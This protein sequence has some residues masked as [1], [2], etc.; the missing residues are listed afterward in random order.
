[1]DTLVNINPSQ[2]LNELVKK[3][4]SENISVSICQSEKRYNTDGVFFSA[5]QEFIHIDIKASDKSM[6][7]ILHKKSFCEAIINHYVTK[8]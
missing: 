3:S 6:T 2:E 8:L 4:S 7:Y 5:N 1:M